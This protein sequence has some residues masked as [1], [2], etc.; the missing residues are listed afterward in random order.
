MRDRGQ[1]E[2]Q[3][4]E[5]LRTTAIILDDYD[6]NSPIAAACFEKAEEAVRASK[7]LIE[8]SDTLIEQLNRDLVR[9]RSSTDLIAD[10]CETSFH[11]IRDAHR[12][13]ESA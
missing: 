12:A 6:L 2:E 3:M 13:P 5:V 8:R 4:Y 9:T 11:E 7:L 1:I 10:E